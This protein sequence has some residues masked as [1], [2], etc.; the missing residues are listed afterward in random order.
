MHGQYIFTWAGLTDLSLLV[1][2]KW[3]IMSYDSFCQQYPVQ[4]LML[5]LFSITLLGTMVN[6]FVV[7]EIISDIYYAEHIAYDGIKAKLYF[8]FF[9]GAQNLAYGLVIEC[10][11]RDL[12]PFWWLPLVLL[13]SEPFWMIRTLVLSSFSVPY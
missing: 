4:V 1:E 13:Y 12:G 6:Q 9:Y 2:F 11:W 8:L 10:T 5:L 3:Q 7:W